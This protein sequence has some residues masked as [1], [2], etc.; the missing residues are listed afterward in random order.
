MSEWN[1]TNC[2]CQVL[3]NLTND[4]FLHTGTA[5]IMQVNDPL[6]RQYRVCV[7]DSCG[8]R[9]MCIFYHCTTSYPDL[10]SLAFYAIPTFHILN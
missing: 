1:R 8:V 6:M 2:S 7:I 10:V 5:E 9:I 3:F 4:F